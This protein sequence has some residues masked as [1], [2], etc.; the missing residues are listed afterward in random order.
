M[1][2]DLGWSSVINRVLA[3]GYGLQLQP[4]DDNGNPMLAVTILS[5]N[6][7]IVG[8]NVF[9]G[10]DH[11]PAQLLAWVEQCAASVF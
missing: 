7:S 3:L 4:F 2:G 6:D 5:V 10:G 9:A 8:Y 1:Y 11:L